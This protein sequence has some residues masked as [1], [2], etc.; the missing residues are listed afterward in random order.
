MQNG[1][2]GIDDDHRPFKE[3]GVPIVH[4]IPVP[5]PKVWHKQTDNEKAIDND[6]KRNVLNVRY[7]C[8]GLVAYIQDSHCRVFWTFTHSFS[9]KNCFE[10]SVLTLPLQPAR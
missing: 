4:V 6:G 3:L 1:R 7:S 10:T 2:T 8:S 9:I 5:F